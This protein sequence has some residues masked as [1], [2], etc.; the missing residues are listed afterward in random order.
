M[1]RPAGNKQFH[2]P[3]MYPTAR[4]SIPRYRVISGFLSLLI[5]FGILSVGM[6]YDAASRSDLFPPFFHEAAR[7]DAKQGTTL[8]AWNAIEKGPA[9][10]VIPFAQTASRIDPDLGIALQPDS[11]FHAGQIFY[12]TYS[13]QYPRTA[14]TVTVKWYVDH[15]IVQ[16]LTT[17]T[18]PADKISNGYAAILYTSASSGE[19]EL[20]WNNQ[21]AQRLSFTVK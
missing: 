2:I 19:V 4:A 20:Y 21:L 3:A 5:V 8:P 14:G 17:P 10:E 16:L 13:I 12:V 9:Y 15:S 18:I 7:S 6:A 11:V 1:K